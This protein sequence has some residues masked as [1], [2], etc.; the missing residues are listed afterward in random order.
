MNKQ[1]KDTRTQL[2][3][4]TERR[5]EGKK[6]NEEW[7]QL[8]VKFYLKKKRW[9]IEMNI[10]KMVK[11]MFKGLLMVIRKRRRRR[12]ETYKITLQKQEMEKKPTTH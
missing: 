8:D 3:T 6:Q 1:R 4:N 7:R 5:K 2:K 11:S 12:R 9:D 10:R